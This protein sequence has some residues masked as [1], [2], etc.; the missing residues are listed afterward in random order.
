MQRYEVD[1]PLLLSHYAYG[2][3]G[4]MENPELARGLSLVSGGCRQLEILINYPKVKH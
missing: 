2:S 3:R 4:I 1:S